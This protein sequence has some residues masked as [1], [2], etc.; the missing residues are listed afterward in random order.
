MDHAQVSRRHFGQH[1][2]AIVV[3][4]YCLWRPAAGDEV[5][6][7]FLRSGKRHTVEVSLGQR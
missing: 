5:T 2:R 6:V 7:E 3:G 4:A 1:R